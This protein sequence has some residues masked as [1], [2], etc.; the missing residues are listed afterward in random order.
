MTDALRNRLR[1]KLLELRDEIIREGDL[2]IA[3]VRD[4][5]EA[6]VDEDAAPL[7][8][9]HQVIASKRNRARTDVLARV[10]AAL[11]RIEE[12]PEMFGLCRNCEE[13]IGKRLE[14]LPYVE[15]CTECQ[16]ARDGSPRQG[17]RRNLRDLG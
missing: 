14:L 7:T 10:Q 17:S 2:T 13:P 16:Q 3:P 9:M 11:R 12:D 4:A 6:K 8:E 5:N 15:L 1:R